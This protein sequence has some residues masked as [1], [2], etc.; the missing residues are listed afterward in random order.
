[1]KYNQAEYN[2]RSLEKSGKK[3]KAFTLDAETLA[4]FEAIAE[5]S[6]LSHAEILRRGVRLVAESVGL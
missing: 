2:R 6:G 5:K 1:M 4:L 3:T